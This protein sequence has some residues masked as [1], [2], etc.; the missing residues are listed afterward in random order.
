MWWCSGFL[1]C[2]LPTAGKVM[3]VGQWRLRTLITGALFAACSCARR[4]ISP[5]FGH[6]SRL[7][8]IF[9][10]TPGNG[11][12]CPPPHREEEL[13]FM[14]AALWES[15]HVLY[16]PQGCRICKKTELNL[17]IPDSEVRRGNKTL[18][19]LHNL[20]PVKVGRFQMLIINH[21]TFWSLSDLCYKAFETGLWKMIN[22]PKLADILHWI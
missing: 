11:L 15:R 2:R 17:Q 1:W 4:T 12:L 18:K 3:D 8:S 21:F 9:K 6:V 19:T 13:G 14:T 7:P 22:Y 16:S 5:D 20:L 10:F